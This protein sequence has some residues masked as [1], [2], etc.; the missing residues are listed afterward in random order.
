MIQSKLQRL[1]DVTGARDA[2]LQHAIRMI[3]YHHHRTGLRNALQVGEIDLHIHFHFAQQI[4]QDRARSSVA[5]SDVQVVRLLQGQKP[6]GK[7]RQSREQGRAF[8]H[9]RRVSPGIR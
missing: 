8:Q 2:F 4:F 6:A 7:R 5:R 9:T 1:V 3:C